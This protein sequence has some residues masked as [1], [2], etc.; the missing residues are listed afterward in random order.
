MYIIEHMEADE[1]TPSSLPPWVMLEYTHIL[2]RTYQ[3]SSTSSSP[4]ADAGGLNKVFFTNLSDK[5]ASSLSTQFQQSASSSS[6]SSSAASSPSRST[7]PR[8][9]VYALSESVDALIADG[10]LPP[11]PRVCLLDPKA[12]KA[13]CPEDAEHFDAFLFGGILGD[14]PPRDRT[15]QLRQLGFEGR[16]LDTVQMTTDTA[17][18]VTSL[19]VDGGNALDALP[20][21]D[22]P[23]IQFNEQ[24]SVEMPFRYVRN[25]ADGLPTMPTGM[26]ELLYEDLNKGFEDF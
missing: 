6:S 20:Y 15:A 17:V 13:L 25:S 11:K 8:S 24:E 22:H 2:E 14:D 10:K 1:S 18:Y 12:P 3:P 23:T 5:A 19:V 9:T 21:I 4:E 16:H 26:R 7:P